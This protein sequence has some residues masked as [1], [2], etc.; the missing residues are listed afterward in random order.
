MCVGE[1]DLCRIIDRFRPQSLSPRSSFIHQMQFGCIKDL[2]H[3]SLIF[4]FSLQTFHLRASSEVE[5]QRWVTALEF[6]KAKA[7]QRMESE[8]DENQ[9]DAPVEMDKQVS[10]ADGSKLLLSNRSFRVRILT[11]H[12]LGKRLMS[13]NVEIVSNSIGPPPKPVWTV[14][15]FC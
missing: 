6:A 14:S 1:F 4:V 13:C 7:I 11:L 5:R 10:R 15:F 8:E 2:R 12:G 3:G 9:D